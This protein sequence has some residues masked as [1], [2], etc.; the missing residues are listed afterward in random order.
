M[1]AC[2]TST[3]ASAA[4]VTSRPT[5]LETSTPHSSWRGCGRN[6]RR[7]RA[8]FSRGH[9]ALLLGWLR[10]RVHRQGQRHAPQALMTHATGEPTQARFHFEYLRRKFA[11]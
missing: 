10:D 1:A 5:P 6:N 3:G 4:W 8:I 2:K 9:Y 7:W 11:E